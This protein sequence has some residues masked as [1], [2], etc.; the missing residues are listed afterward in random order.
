EGT[1]PLPASPSVKRRRTLCRLLGRLSRLRGEMKLS[2]EA[3]QRYAEWLER[4]E[5]EAAMVDGRLRGWRARLGTTALKAALI[6]EAT[7]TGRR[8]VSVEAMGGATAFLKEVVDQLA[9]SMSRGGE[10]GR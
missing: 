5:C 8:T 1:L 7:L 10:G 2:G 4:V 3:R 6:Y 9:E